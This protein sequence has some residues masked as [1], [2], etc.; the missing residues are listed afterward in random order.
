MSTTTSTATTPR[1]S[2][3]IAKS[4]FNISTSSITSQSSRKLKMGELWQSIKRHAHEHHKSVNAAYA[5]FHGP[6][7][8]RMVA[9]GQEHMQGETQGRSGRHGEVWVYER[10]VYGR[11]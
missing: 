7:H 11:L 8:E 4:N 10:G 2:I 5:I 6:G 1:S 3:D 9:L